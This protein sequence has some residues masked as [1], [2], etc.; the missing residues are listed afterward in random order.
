MPYLLASL[1]QFKLFNKGDIPT[2]LDT[3]I[4]QLLGQ[5]TAQLAGHCRRLTWDKTTFT[6]YVDHRTA[7]S[8][9]N[10]LSVP[11]LS[12]RDSVLWVRHAPID[13]AVAVTLYDDPAR[14]FTAASLVPATAYIIIAEE[15]RVELLT[16]AFAPGLQSTRVSYT[17]GYLT[18]DGVSADAR[19][20]ALQHACCLQ[21][22]FIYQ[23]RAE[24]GA[25]GRSLEGG[26][27]QLDTPIQLLPAVEQMLSAFRPKRI[28]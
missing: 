14:V 19:F 26:S 13:T 17:G 20:P 8:R 23:R 28:G 18:A 25:A 3:A 24:I 21:T 4:T 9:W 22:A 12:A 6:E 16:G 7:P 2:S 10:L 15:G 5:V 11:P 27:I 1:A